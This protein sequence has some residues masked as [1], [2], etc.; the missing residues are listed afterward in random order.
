MLDKKSSIQIKDKGISTKTPPQ[1]NRLKS[2][3]KRSTHYYPTVLLPGAY[4]SW[5]MFSV[6]SGIWGGYCSKRFKCHVYIISLV[7]ECCAVLCSDL[8]LWCDLFMSYYLLY[9][10][11]WRR[12]IHF[13]FNKCN[14]STKNGI[15]IPA[16]IIIF[17][18]II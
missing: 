5:R 8:Y 12:K 7:Y 6:M 11:I 3:T 9:W 14:S 13:W 15:F 10:I 4:L 18:N 17:S 1:H 16:T 2:T